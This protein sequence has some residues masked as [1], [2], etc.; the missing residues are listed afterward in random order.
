[1]DGAGK[2][3]LSTKWKRDMKRE[4]II[5][6]LRRYE[7]AIFDCVQLGR[8]EDADAELEA[9]REDLADVLAECE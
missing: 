4:D 7:D 3:A 9:A 5:A 6:T 1:M 2:L 8:T